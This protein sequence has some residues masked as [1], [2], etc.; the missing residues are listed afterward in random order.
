MID[1]GVFFIN[2][3]VQSSCLIV[4]IDLNRVMEL[5]DTGFSFS[6]AHALRMGY[7]TEKYRN[8]EVYSFKIGFYYAESAAVGVMVLFIG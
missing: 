5:L 1:N 6:G 4:L 2:I 3:V 7:K 8:K